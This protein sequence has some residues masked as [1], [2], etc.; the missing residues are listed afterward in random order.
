M[1]YFFARDV[2]TKFNVPVGL[3][4]SRCGATPAE[5]WT[6]RE[7]LNGLPELKAEVARQVAEM[8]RAPGEQAAWPA[9]QA[10]WEKQNGVADTDNAG[11]KNGWA[12]PDF[13]DQAW[14]S[15]KAPFNF[16]T[17]TS[18]KAGGVLWLRIDSITRHPG[19]IMIGHH[20]RERIDRLRQAA[21]KK[22]RVMRVVDQKTAVAP[23]HADTLADPNK[24]LASVRSLLEL[25]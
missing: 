20:D 16:Q 12:A 21:A 22:G 17:A 25:G 24:L 10:A 1:S 7:V 11:L 4:A 23:L 15:V 5:A 3:I 9:L 8:E 13:D 18:S 14:T 6:R 19:M 2:H